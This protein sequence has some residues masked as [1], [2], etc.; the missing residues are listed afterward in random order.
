[1]DYKSLWITAEYRCRELQAQLDD[2]LEEPTHHNMARARAEVRVKAQREIDE[3]EE[4]NTEMHE[5]VA[6]TQEMNDHQ[7]ALLKALREKVHDLTER[8]TC[9]KEAMCLMVKSS[10][11]KRSRLLHNTNESS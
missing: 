10:S 1:M 5:M 9:L 6:D 11:R 2:S 7:E 3:L 4:A 8:N